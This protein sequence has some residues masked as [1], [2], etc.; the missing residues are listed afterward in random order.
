[1]DLNNNAIGFDSWSS[2]QPTLEACKAWQDAKIKFLQ[3][4][5]YKVTLD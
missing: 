4:L 5:G 3:D 2:N 1:M